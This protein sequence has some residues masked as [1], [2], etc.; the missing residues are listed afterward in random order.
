M[1]RRFVGWVPV[2]AGQTNLAAG[3]RPV[4]KSY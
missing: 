2:G 4:S 1:R 3:L